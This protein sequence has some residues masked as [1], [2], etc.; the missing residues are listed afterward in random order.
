[1][2]FFSS[3]FN[4][5]R[6][7]RNLLLGTGLLS[8]SICLSSCEPIF[9][10]QSDC[11]YGK[12]LRFIFDY[13]MEPGANA[14]P[15]NVDCVDVLVYDSNGNY[16]TKFTETSEELRNEGYRMHM[17]LDPGTYNLVV[18]G[19]TSCENNTFTLT[20]STATGRA[21]QH[22]MQVTLNTDE[23]GVSKK[24]LHDIDARTGGL[25]YGTHTFTIDPDDRS[26][27]GYK[28]ETVN[29]MK[30]T[31][32]IQVILQELTGDNSVDFKDYTFR[33]VDD[34][35]VLDASNVS[36]STSTADVTPTYHPH[37]SENRTVGYIDIEGS[38]EGTQAEEDAKKPVQVAVAEF[39]TNRLL[40]DHIGT[41]RLKVMSS[42][43]HEADGSDKTIIDI[44]LIE[45]LLLTR[46]MGENWI[47]TD[48][49]YLDRQSRWTMMFFLQRNVWLNTKIVVNSWVVRLNNIDLGW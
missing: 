12:A 31:N 14:F 6:S 42:L 29:V 37:N 47:K 21:A 19:G 13:H 41:A 16:V 1:M 24:Q 27:N 3:I 18:W 43:E 10:D 39:S 28:E 44:P 17:P 5:N 26:S 20:H 4:N 34:N 7:R 49:E 30:N 23:P 48:Q 40:M 9:D 33:I 35:F 36:I 15:A 25:F 46:G 11:D 8:L 2:K 22:D 32:T 45:Y 38:K